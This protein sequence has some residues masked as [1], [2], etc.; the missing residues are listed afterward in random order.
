MCPWISA[1]KIIKDYHKQTPKHFYNFTLGLPYLE[2]GQQYRREEFERNIISDEQFTL[3]NKERLVCGIDQGNHFHVLTGF[4]N[5]D[6]LITTRA[7]RFESTN[8]L[9]AFLDTLKPDMIVMDIFPDQHYAKNL[10]EKYGISNVIL[11]NQRLWVDATKSKG[12]ME[13]DRV[14]GYV[15]L[16]KTESIDHMMDKLRKGFI[17]FSA[18]MYGQQDLLNHLQN[19]IPDFETRFGFKRKVYKKVGQ[20]HFASSLNFLTIA[21]EILYPEFGSNETRLV[22]SSN[23]IPTKLGSEEWIK[24]NME[25]KIMGLG[26]GGGR[27]IVIPPKQI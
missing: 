22:Q 17:K 3:F 27:V 19:V 23:Y 2:K 10:Q 15:K 7:K 20:D 21:C 13:L 18:S 12:F 6:G 16:E 1:E 24:E 11:A 25:K 5:R 26:S 14:H 4:A 9:E 8:E